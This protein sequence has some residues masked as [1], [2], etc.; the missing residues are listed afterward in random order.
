MKLFLALVGALW[1]TVAVVPLHAQSLLGIPGTNSSDNDKQQT[2]EQEV[3][4]LIRLLSKPELVEKLRE[5]LTV[6]AG[7]PDERELIVSGL[8]KYFRAA[9]SRIEGRL[10]DIVQAAKAVPELSNALSAAWHER[11]AAD[12]FLQSPIYVI[13]FLFGG[14]GLE[15]LYWSYMSGSL[16]R[17][18]LSKPK[19]YGSILKAAMLRAALLFG[20]IAIFGFGLAAIRVS[21]GP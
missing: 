12:N 5:R 13:I 21:P 19:T 7:D 15:W 1:L 3:L 11:I 10:Q 18:E 9:L 20:S 17:I 6:S 4:E 8:Q 14:F 16:K 2:S